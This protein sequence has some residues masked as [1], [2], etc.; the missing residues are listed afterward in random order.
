MA[1]TQIELPQKLCLV[2]RHCATDTSLLIADKSQQAALR[3]ARAN[4]T[5]NSIEYITSTSASVMDYIS[6]SPADTV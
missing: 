1:R 2:L 4:L 3:K 5:Q 6:R